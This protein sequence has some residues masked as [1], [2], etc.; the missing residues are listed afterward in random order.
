MSSVQYRLVIRRGPNP[1]QTFELNRDTI[2][3]G[4]DITNDVVINDPEISRHHA[5]LVRSGSGYAI[6]DLRSTN[7]TFVN[8]QRIAGPQQLANGDLI[9]FGETVTLAYEVAGAPEQVT[10]ASGGPSR[11]DVAQQRVPPPAP[12]QPAYSAPPP[13]SGYQP[14]YQYA[15]EEEEPDRNR[16]IV[17]GCAVLTVVFCCA[18]VGAAILIDQMNLYCDIPVMQNMSFF[19][20]P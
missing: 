16:W 17:I 20:V 18:L 12:P 1:N 13:P 5:R 11:G 19:C 7:A 3:I 6:E 8:R 14:D 2:T 9:G 10:L 4:R 15:E